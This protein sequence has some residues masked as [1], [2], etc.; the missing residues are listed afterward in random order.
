MDKYYNIEKHPRGDKMLLDGTMSYIGGYH[1][2]DATH[3]SGDN[4]VPQSY[5]HVRAA[6]A[7]QKGM[8]AEELLRYEAA[9]AEQPR[10]GS[11]VIIADS[12]NET[13]NRQR[14]LYGGS[15]EINAKE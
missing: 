8:T 7:K 10:I 2:N 4:R 12:S 3:V 11:G 1:Q 13:V 6:A 5:E 15:P 14:R 9:M